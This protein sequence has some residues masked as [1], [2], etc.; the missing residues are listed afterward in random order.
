MIK[1]SE[2]KIVK[3]IIWPILFNGFNINVYLLQQNQQGKG[4][5]EIQN[6]IILQDQLLKFSQEVN[7]NLGF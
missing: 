7:E 4:F 1:S 2:K 6:S 5:K 3:E